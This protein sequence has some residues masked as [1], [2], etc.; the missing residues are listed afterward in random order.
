MKRLGLWLFVVL[1]TAAAWWTAL[2]TPSARSAAGPVEGQRAPSRTTALDL[3][4]ADEVLIV[5]GLNATRAEVGLPPVEV[6]PALTEKADS[7]AEETA[8]TGLRHSDLVEGLHESLCWQKLGENIAE[9]ETVEEILAAW[10]A[11]PT[12]YANLTDPV[13]THVGVSV[14]ADA[15]GTLF[16]TQEFMQA[17][18]G[19]SG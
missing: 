11:S 12:H 4:S 16:A 7:W 10:E 18:P 13:F 2:A 19:C 6:E 14:V 3:L 15:A 5:E 9:G 8:E 1:V 17:A